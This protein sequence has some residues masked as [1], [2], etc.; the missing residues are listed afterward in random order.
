MYNGR[1]LLS[2]VILSFSTIL[3]GTDQLPEIFMYKKHHEFYY[4]G[5]GFGRGYPLYPLSKYKAYRDKINMGT[6][7]EIS[8][9]SQSTDCYR[10]YQ[11]TWKIEDNTL[12]LSELKKGCYDDENI[13]DLK[14]I[15]GSKYTKHGLK[16][17]WITDTIT[18]T[19]EPINVSTI[20]HTFSFLTLIVEQGLIVKIIEEGP[21]FAPKPEYIEDKYNLASNQLPEIIMYEDERFYAKGEWDPLSNIL[22]D[23]KY[24]SR[25]N[26]DEYGALE[27]SS[28]FSDGCYR[29]YQGIWK[30]NNDTL[31]LKELQD[32]CT[33]EPIFDLEKIFGK[34]TVTPKGIR[35]FWI[36]Q[37]LIVSSKEINEFELKKESILPTYLKLNIIRGVVV[38][39]EIEKD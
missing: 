29:S 27:L 18:L 28:C 25:M 20:C 21:Y 32:F 9:A 23:D 16:A 33:E 22:V 24:V 36:S 37:E 1:I 17:F 2:L 12:F 14:E 35:A 31:Y 15:F 38:K 10:G 34:E 8:G 13:I 39:K 30:I 11:G 5:G 6:N 4:S 3:Y 19:N 7:G 26:T